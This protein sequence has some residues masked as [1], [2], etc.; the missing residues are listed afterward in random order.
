MLRLILRRSV[1]VQKRPRDRR[2]GRRPGYRILK[3]PQ[4]PVLGEVLLDEPVRM[5]WVVGL[6]FVEEVLIS[7]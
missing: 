5:A 6:K 2:D 4:M 3:R 1:L 7:P